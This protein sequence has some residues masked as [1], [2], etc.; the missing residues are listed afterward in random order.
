MTP[1]TD[2]AVGKPKALALWFPSAHTRLPPTPDRAPAPHGPM[3]AGVSLSAPC[4]LPHISQ[5]QLYLGHSWG[6]GLSSYTGVCPS[7][8]LPAWDFSDRIPSHLL[9]KPGENRKSSWAWPLVPHFCFSQDCVW[10]GTKGLK[11]HMRH[12]CSYCTKYCG[13]WLVCTKLLIARL[14]ALVFWLSVG[15]PPL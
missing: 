1:G 5:S 10:L 2:E 7:S 6:P 12:S 8:H 15:I 11:G 9:T 14:P 13:F 4:L 3:V